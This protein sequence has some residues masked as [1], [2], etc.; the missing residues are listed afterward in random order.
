MMLKNI[1]LTGLIALFLLNS[2]EKSNIND[3]DY[4]KYIGV[5]NNESGNTTRTLEV[6][7][8]G[9]SFYE[10]VT[11]SGNVAKSLSYNGNFILEGSTLKIG[12]KKL[13]INKEPT[14]SN[15]YWYLIMDNNEYLKK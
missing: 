2:C 10:E 12:F 9:K 6:K 5:W 1:L 13:T 15:G 3:F 11:K 7:S 4:H 8:N 14:V